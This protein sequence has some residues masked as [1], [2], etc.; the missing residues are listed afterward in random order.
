V[1]HFSDMIE[2]IL[3]FRVFANISIITYPFSSTPSSPAIPPEDHSINAK[4]IHASSNATTST[5]PPNARRDSYATTPTTIPPRVAMA[6][7]PDSKDSHANLKSFMWI[8]ESMRVPAGLAASLPVIV[9]TTV[10]T[11]MWI[12]GCK[13]TPASVE[14]SD[15]APAIPKCAMHPTTEKRAIPDIALDPT[16]ASWEVPVWDS[17]LNWY[18]PNARRACAT[19]RMGAVPVAMGFIVRILCVLVMAPVVVE[20]EEVRVPWGMGWSFPDPAD[21]LYQATLAMSPPMEEMAYP[22]ARL[23]RECVSVPLVGEVG[24]EITMSVDDTRALDWED[25]RQRV[26]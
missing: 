16:G 2:T 14:E 15:A 17:V 13:S 3:F 23:A 26:A 22:P 10:A 24:V 12:R 5:T 8:W 4:A 11:R 9:V 18:S 25:R 21:K 1:S 20:W 7:A 6:Y 19:Y